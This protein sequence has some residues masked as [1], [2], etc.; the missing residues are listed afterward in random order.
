MEHAVIVVIALVMNALL[1][2]PKALVD[3]LGISPLLHWPARPLRTMERKL[4]REHRSDG[5]RQ[6]RGLV[7]VAA[8]F[9][10]SVVVGIIVT[11][12]STATGRFL[13]VVLLFLLIP[14]R[15]TWDVASTI[16]TALI[17]QK[18]QLA[19]Q[20]L[21][22][23][24]WRHHA[25][26]DA[27]GV[28]RAAVEYQAVQFAEKIFAP[29]MWYLLGGLPGLFFCL[30]VTLMYETFA[31]SGSAFGK[32]AQGVYLVMHWIP[33]RMVACM[34]IVAALFQSR[35]KMKQTAASIWQY[36]SKTDH[37]T[38]NAQAMPSILPQALQVACIATVLQ[39]TL[40]GPP[41]AYTAKAWL[42]SGTVKLLPEHI[43]TAQ[44][45]FA[46]QHLLLL[47]LL[48]VVM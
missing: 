14:V 39:V 11:A 48:G 27:H 33:S 21:E 35:G 18:L 31:I 43:R 38:K 15:P 46:V 3:R 26:L 4:N 32:P 30:L 1:A 2:G 16:R 19:Q 12:I 8:I 45:L 17:D 40:G 41:S 37:G 5:E 25:R 29:V 23:T 24:V 44:Y 9:I 34:W 36:M 6:M 13:D 28:A 42:G 10:L 47:L 7:V 20:A 22:G